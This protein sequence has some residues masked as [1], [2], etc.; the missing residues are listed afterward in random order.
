MTNILECAC[1][2]SVPV[3][4]ITLGVPLGLALIGPQSSVAQPGSGYE[5]RGNLQSEGLSG[6]RT[7]RT[8]TSRTPISVARHQAVEYCVERAQSQVPFASDSAVQQRSLIYAS[9]MTS[10]GQRP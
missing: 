3:L 4:A 1:R 7:Q 5:T 10:Y 6:Q 9:C 8:Q 2:A